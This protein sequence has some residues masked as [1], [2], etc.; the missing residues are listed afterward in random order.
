[1]F[2]IFERTADLHAAGCIALIAAAMLSLWGAAGLSARRSRRGCAPGVCETV[3]CQWLNAPQN[4]PHDVY[5][6]PDY[7]GENT[8]C[9]E[10]NNKAIIKGV[11]CL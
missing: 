6:V 5:V 7:A 8:E 9:E 11:T 1:M 10:G 2:R 3:S 4:D